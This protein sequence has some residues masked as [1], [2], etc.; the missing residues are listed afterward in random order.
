MPKK[1]DIEE[2]PGDF[3]SFFV[4]PENRKTY[5][6]DGK[7]VAPKGGQDPEVK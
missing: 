5:K 3:N 4:M 7:I 2:E 6:N 1:K